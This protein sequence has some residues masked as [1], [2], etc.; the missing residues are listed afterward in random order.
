MKCYISPFENVLDQFDAMQAVA[1]KEFKIQLNF[2]QFDSDDHTFDLLEQI[3][4]YPIAS[5]YEDP[6]TLNSKKVEAYIELP[7]RL[8][9][10]IAR[11][12]S[13]IQHRR[14]AACQ[15]VCCRRRTLLHPA[16]WQ[17]YYAFHDNAHTS[18]L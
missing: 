6:L 2:T 7:N 1:L 18:R 10:P 12:A 9:L 8:R 16:R 4:H 13:T 15:A 11:H 5:L 14:D 3:S 17:P